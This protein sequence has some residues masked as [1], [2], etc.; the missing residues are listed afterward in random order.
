MKKYQGRL[1]TRQ[2]FWKTTYYSREFSFLFMLLFKIWIHQ[3]LLTIYR[4]SI[5][6]KKYF[7]SKFRMSQYTIRLKLSR[8]FVNI[9]FL[10]ISWMRILSEYH[11]LFHLMLIFSR[12]EFFVV[13]PNKKQKHVLWNMHYL[14]FT[15]FQ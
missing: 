9:L 2:T 7:T 3:T 15:L 13:F 11:Y 14:T 10:N 12:P 1:M 5:N 4:I 8:K 6:I